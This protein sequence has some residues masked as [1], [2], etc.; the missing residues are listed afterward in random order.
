MEKHAK[1]KAKDALKRSGFKRFDFAEAP[2]QQTWLDDRD[3][4]S[5]RRFARTRSMEAERSV[6][7]MPQDKI[8]YFQD[9]E[10]PIDT[11]EQY[12]L[13]RELV[14]ETSGCFVISHLY[15]PLSDVPT[16][17]GIE[18]LPNRTRLLRKR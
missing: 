13:R 14:L 17:T 1:E 6:K 15:D 10:R 7:L 3:T 16:V 12:P 9:I 11:R 5:Q 18:F 4:S 2:I 8:R